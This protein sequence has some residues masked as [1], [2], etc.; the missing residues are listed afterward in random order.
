MAP[1]GPCLI[2]YIH[3]LFVH[4]CATF[5]SKLYQLI[6]GHGWSSILVSVNPCITK[7]TVLEPCAQLY[8]VSERLN[9]INWTFTGFTYGLVRSHTVS[10]GLVRS[11][12]R[13]YT[14]M[15]PVSLFFNSFKNHTQLSR[16]Q[17]NGPSVTQIR[18][19]LVWLYVQFTQ[20]A[21]RLKGNLLTIDKVQNVSFFI[22]TLSNCTNIKFNTKT[23]NW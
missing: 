6:P 17:S 9:S 3:A 18:Q 23:V 7:Y 16:I 8:S 5:E 10:H 19:R 2:E 13:L 11:L 22:S 1:R 12:I 20:M 14:D 4:T 15:A 21:N